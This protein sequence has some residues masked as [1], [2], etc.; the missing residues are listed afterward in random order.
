MD[1]TNQT[2]Q[3]KSSP[4]GT[5]VL[6]KVLIILIILAL[7]FWAGMAVGIHKAE[8][9]YRFGDNYMN[10]FGVRRGG[11]TGMMGI[12]DTNDLVNGHGAVG[13]VLSVSLPKIIVSDRDGIEKNIILNND[14]VVRSA[15]T[16]IASTS[17]KIDDF[18]VVIGDPSD[19][20]SI[21]AKL[22]RLMPPMMVNASSTN[23]TIQYRN[24]GPNMM[25]SNK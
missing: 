7:A 4:I 5:S 18:V 24:V 16:T 12:T 10:A 17:I 23:G 21:V 13:K 20:G 8:F 14:T 11:F 9:S 19:N 2:G 22:I 1:T 3:N 6:V 15:R 25:Y